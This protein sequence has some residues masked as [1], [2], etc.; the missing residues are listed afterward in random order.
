MGASVR[1]S[2]SEIA[3]H[4]LEV[5]FNYQTSPPTAETTFMVFVRGRDR[6][7][8]MG[9]LARPV[10]MEVKLRKELGRW[11]VYGDP[12]HDAG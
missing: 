3:I 9:E 6:R 5:K 10:A 7:G 8:E 2:F 11:L 4:S 1:P 12:K